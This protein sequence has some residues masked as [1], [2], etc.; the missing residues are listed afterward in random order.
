MKYRRLHPEELDS[1]RED[2]VQFLAANSLPA[3]DWIKLKKE[4]PD[5]AEKM[6]EMFS[7][8]VWDKVLGNVKYLETRTQKELRVVEFEDNTINMIVLK[9][10][11]EDMNFTSPEHIRSISEGNVDLMS[12]GLEVLTGNRDY[13]ADKK[14]EV[15]AMMES[16]SRPCKEVFW[17]SIKKMIPADN[18]APAS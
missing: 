15:F 17:L 7:D 16:G 1:L 13:R 2:F 5:Q 4:M 6:I 10:T 11:S 18:S 8:L 3:D 9:I 14:M 12:H